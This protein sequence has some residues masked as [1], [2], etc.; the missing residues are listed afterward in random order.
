MGFYFFV[1][2]KN[3]DVS[4]LA[5]NWMGDSETILFF[6]DLDHLKERTF[7]SDFLSKAWGLKIREFG[8]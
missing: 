2:K 7:G 8:G 3:S 1:G 6:P 5:S 4:I